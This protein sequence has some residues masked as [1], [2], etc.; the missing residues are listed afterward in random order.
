MRSAYTYA[1]GLAD[2]P[3]KS[4]QMRFDDIDSIRIIYLSIHLCIYALFI[5]ICFFPN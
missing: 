1:M 3:V 5:R 2:R 4:N